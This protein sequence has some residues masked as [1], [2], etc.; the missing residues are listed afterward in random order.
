[1]SDNTPLENENG[2]LESTDT[3][4]TE[5]DPSTNSASEELI[6]AVARLNDVDPVELPILADFIDPE[7]LDAL[8]QPREDGTLRRTSGQVEFTYGAYHVMVYS[9]GAINLSPHRSNGTVA[10]SETSMR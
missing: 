1:M 10:F 9:Q 7:A 2:E 5:F 3:H 4:V 8:F 6:K